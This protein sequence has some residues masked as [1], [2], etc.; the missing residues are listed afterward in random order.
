M[1]MVHFIPPSQ[2]RLALLAAQADTAPVLI[3]GADGTGKSAIAHWI[4][5][6]GPRSTRPY[7]LAD[8]KSPLAK[9][10]PMAQGGT[11]VIHEIGNWPLG[12]Q[13]TILNFLKT[14][15]I[16]GPE[17]GIPM[18]LN[19]RIIAST[20]QTLE[21]RAQSG[22]FNDELL[23]RLNVFRIEMPALAKRSDEFEDIVK[24]LMSEITH[25]LHKE[26]L[27]SLSNESWMQLKSYDWPG[28]IRELR[29]VL[30]IAVI[31]A[32]GESLEISDFPEFGPERVNF[33]ATR[34]Q[35]EKIYI[36]ELLKTFN[37]QIDKTCQM[38]RMDKKTL[39]TKIDQYGI[40][41]QETSIR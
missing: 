20:S 3:H 37:W 32:R 1:E 39:L 29:N 4:H 27:R 30:R 17:Q 22:M 21:G 25:E 10:I 31:N 19:V 24:G 28:N 16:T 41:L 2:R 26:H 36:L 15:T 40:R 8:H 33:R 23:Q 9:Q 34:E 18:L 6:N 7:V 12:E 35:F 14:R 38:T 5:L 13:K 11:F